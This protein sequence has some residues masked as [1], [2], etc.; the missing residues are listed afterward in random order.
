MLFILAID[1]LHRLIEMAAS[2][3]LLQPVLPRAAALRCSLYADD[4][5]LFANPDRTELN[6]I[7]QILNVFGN[8]LGLR[9]N[10]N[11]TEI[12]PIRCDEATISERLIDFP[13]K[14]GSFPGKYLG[15]PMHTR[16]LRRVD[17]QP[18]LDKIGGRIPGWK[19]KLLTMAGRETL[20]KVLSAQPIYHL[21]F[22]PI[23]K[24]L[25]KQI[26]K[27]RRS[28]FLERRGTRERQRGIMDLD[29]FA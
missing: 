3:G 17:V 23:Q 27:M 12:F 13:G 20:V 9:V 15:L 10:L 5:I 19:G 4:T 6:Y 22:F 26:D 21:T 1:P 28:F 11:K 25:L 8:C 18:L 14:I 7:S 2:R 29:K 16:Q 24:W